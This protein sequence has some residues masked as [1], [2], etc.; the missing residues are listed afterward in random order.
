M[1]LLRSGPHVAQ[2]HGSAV[3]ADA[4][5][6]ALHVHVDPPGQRERD[7]ERRACEERRAHRRMNARFEVAVAREHGTC[8]DV[9]VDDRLLE[10]GV[11]RTRSTNTGAAAIAG[12]GKAELV[13]ERLQARGFEVFADHGRTG[14]ERSLHPRLGGEAPL[15][16]FFRDQP[17]CEHDAWIRRV[18][19]RGDRSD[20]DVAVVDV[21]TVGCTHR[22]FPVAAGRDRLREHTFE[23]RLQV[24]QRNAVL[25]PLRSGH[26]RHDAREVELDH[27]GVID[28]ALAR[29]AETALRPVEGFGRAHALR[30]A[31]GLQQV[32]AGLL[33][34][35]EIADG[36]AVF[37]RHVGD[38]RAVGQRKVR[39]ARAVELDE[40]ADDFRLT[41]HLG[42]AQDE[43]GRG[44]A[45][46]Q[47]PRHVH[48]HDVGCE[49]VDRLA[50]H[51]GF[52]FDAPHAPTDGAQP[53][54]HAGV[55]VGTDE[56]VRIDHAI[57]LEKAWREKLQVELVK[58]APARRHQAYAVIG[59]HRP[60]HEA[61]ALVVALDLQLHVARERVGCTVVID[62]QGVIERHVHR[63]SRTDGLGCVA[64]ARDGTA[65]GGEIAQQRNPCCAVEHDAPDGIRHFVFALS[66]ELPVC[67]RAHLRFGDT[68]AVTVAQQRFEHDAQ[69]HREPGHACDA[70]LFQRRQ[71]VIG[72]LLGE[73]EVY[74]APGDLI[75]GVGHAVIL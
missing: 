21:L 18:G 59:L 47:F 30:G 27:A 14:R 54:D 73:P 57:L 17:G 60:L 61:E 48:A 33:V 3:A 46:L 24:V 71:S 20:N 38:R 5:R 58:N 66:V 29:C 64:H 7:D 55:R 74:F 49:K 72:F 70:V 10:R 13:E 52:G 53:S 12:D 63:H 32:C 37:D 4:E 44:H 68:L 15:H 51:R 42:D 39:D 11:D 41:Q 23:S 36:R 8:N 40:L 28:C 56:R 34:H 26:A 22:S 16:C 31:S 43:I 75:E 65:D 45:V 67:E 25:W 2:V 69:R 1:Q 62:G 19:A 50:E 6:L 9:L 35:R